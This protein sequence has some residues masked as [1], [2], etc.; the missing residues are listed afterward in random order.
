MDYG[1]AMDAFQAGLKDWVKTR[2]GNA[3]IEQLGDKT[4]FVTC[5]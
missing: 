5:S 1:L 3:H 4:T 2:H